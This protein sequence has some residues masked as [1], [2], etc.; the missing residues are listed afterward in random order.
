MIC[1]K[2]LFIKLVN[3]NNLYFTTLM[4]STGVRPSR[5]TSHKSRNKD[6]PRCVT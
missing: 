4:F 2:C 6:R 1:L 5:K 3:I